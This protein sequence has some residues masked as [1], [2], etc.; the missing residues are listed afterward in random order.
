[1]RLDSSGGSFL[2][3]DYV[4]RKAEMRAN[5]LCLSLFG[6]VMFC[7]V[8]AFFVT[9]RQWLQVRREQ[10]NITKQYS[11][12]STKIEQLNLLKEQKT[13]MLEKAEITTALIEKVPRSRL[14]T[15]LVNRM[16]QDI[17]L[18][19][20]ALV[21]KRIKDPAVAPTAGGDKGPAIKSL[22]PVK[23]ASAPAAGP[24]RPGA[25][26]PVSKDPKPAP[27]KPQAPKFEYTLQLT[28]VAKV[29]A[30][31]ADYISALKACPFLDGVDL[32][33]IKE[34]TI[35]KLELRKFEIQATIKPD[36]DARDMTTPNEL[37]SSGAVGADPA[38]SA[39]AVVDKGGKKKPKLPSLTVH[40]SGQKPGEE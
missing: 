34:T 28:G 22:A 36:A 11:K 10:E 3:A 40:T 20:L 16:P 37:I 38:R 35:E 12:E 6:V 14:L 5:L 33:Y 30:S 4:A 18:L 27:E 21:S 13:E 24:R 8:A 23:S 31:I 1:M 39:E 7:V 15:E 25:P 9:N 2:P 19:E 29:N 17:T 32:K 26:A